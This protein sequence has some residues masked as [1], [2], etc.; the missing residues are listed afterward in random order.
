LGVNTEGG[1]Y[2]LQNANKRFFA[3]PDRRFAWTSYPVLVVIRFLALPLR[4][5]VSN[6]AQRGCQPAQDVIL[7]H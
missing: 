1:E 5:G 6:A 4:Y 2:E 3:C 7:P